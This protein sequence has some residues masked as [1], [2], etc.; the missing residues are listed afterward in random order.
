MLWWILLGAFAAG[1]LCVAYGVFVERTWFALRTFRLE[2]L[3]P[4]TPPVTI[5][6]LSDLHFTRTD[7]R[8]RRFVESL[9]QADLTIVTGDIL[10]EPEA[11][12]NAVGA[13]R[14]IHGRRASWFVLGSN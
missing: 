3:P 11:V 7:A 8:K 14:A 2:I 12:E 5:L 4:G 6:H 9:P 13:L 10:G 1:L